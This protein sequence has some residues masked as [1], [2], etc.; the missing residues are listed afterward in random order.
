MRWLFGECSDDRRHRDVHRVNKLVA[1]GR[2]ASG[3]I[4]SH[5]LGRRDAAFALLLLL[6]LLEEIH[7]A[8]LAL[9]V[10]VLEGASGLAL[11][12]AS[13]RARDGRQHI[14]QQGAARIN[15][16]RIIGFVQA[17]VGFFALWMVRMVVSK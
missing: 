1:R 7:H 4:W 10:R 8:L 15:L 17:S 9:V 11:G 5:L 16:E 3:L 14:D 2:G 13:F 6:A 12:G